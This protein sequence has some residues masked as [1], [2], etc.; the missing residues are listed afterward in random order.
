MYASTLPVHHP[1]RRSVLRPVVTSV[2]AALALV[3]PVGSASAATPADARAFVD[4]IGVNTHLHYSN[5]IY[6][7]FVMV[8]QRL[9]ELG[10]RHVRDQFD[11]ARRQYVFDRVNNL[12]AAGIKSTLIACQ[13]KPG[14][15]VGEWTYHID[16]AKNKV[17]D[18]LDA[19]EGWNEPDLQGRSQDAKSC[20]YWLYQ[21][22][23]D[24]TYGPPL[25]QPVLGPSVIHTENDDYGNM[26]DYGNPGAD[27][28]NFHTYPGAQKPSGPDYY[29]LAARIDDLRRHQFPGRS[30]PAQATETGYHDAV[31]C[32]PPPGCG[33]H[34][35][36]SQKA[37]AIYLPR[38]FLEYH[39]AGIQRTFSYELFDLFPD[40]E[41]DEEQRNFG[42][43]ENDGSY[44]PSASA[45]KN[46]IGFLDSPS[47]SSRRPLDYTLS[48]TGDPDGS[49]TGGA[50]K[51]SLFQKAD[52]SWWLGLWQDSKVWDPEPRKDISN[53]A[54]RVSVTLPRA[55]NVTAYLPTRGKET[56]GSG[57]WSSFSAGVGDDVLLIKLAD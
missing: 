49:G 17:R 37:E 1:T 5:T 10:V 51:D 46:T 7:D 57:R 23:K 41:R 38:L 53:S 31:N 34:E 22:A 14:Y 3:G 30:V 13:P 15:G 25:G 27:A 19:I 42:L 9:Q 2:L 44:K 33:G 29:P 16:S 50:V 18:S 35:P 11:P 47:V 45:L 36:V 40:P 48:N 32:P 8:K 4:S 24:E 56:Y 20:Q 12:A 55:M 52:G 39:R 26:D 21:H 6:N 43:F 28:G 54:V